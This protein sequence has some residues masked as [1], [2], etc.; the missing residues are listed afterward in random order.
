MEP[1][2][3]DDPGIIYSD[4]CRTITLDGITVDVH[5]YRLEHDP[6]WA[7]EVANEAGNSTLW[8]DLFETDTEA[9]AAFSAT[10]QEEGLQTF[11]DD[12]DFETLH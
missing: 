6:K 4:L 8:D 1:C 2:V 11:L 9:Y 5:I 12:G 7:L 10:V 3:P